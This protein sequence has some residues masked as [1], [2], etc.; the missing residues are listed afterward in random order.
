LLVTIV[1]AI[2]ML[3]VVAVTGGVALVPTK[4]NKCAPLTGGVIVAGGT[5]PVKNVK[6]V[7]GAIV[8]AEAKVIG[9]CINAL[10]TVSIWGKSES[11]GIIFS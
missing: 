2:A 9:F 4:A 11:S 7:S 10:A 6:N 5:V 3:P 1:V 8:A